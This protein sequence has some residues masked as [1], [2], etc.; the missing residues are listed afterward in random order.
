MSTKSRENKREVRYIKNI[1]NSSFN[2]TAKQFITYMFEL[3][4][5]EVPVFETLSS[6]EILRIY[7]ETSRELMDKLMWSRNKP[8]DSEYLDELLYI[9][10]LGVLP[11]SIKIV[12]ESL[13]VNNN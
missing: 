12:F 1:I 2:E 7:S 6:D 10:S 11:K 9:N 5:K 13:K 4:G 8:L 3:D